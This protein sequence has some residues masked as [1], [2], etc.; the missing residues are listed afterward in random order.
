MYDNDDGLDNSTILYI[1]RVGDFIAAGTAYSADGGG[2]NFFD[3]NGW[4]R[5]EGFDS[6]SS[7]DPIRFSN[8]VW[9]I[10]GD[11]NTGGLWV[12][13]EN[14]V[15][16]YDWEGNWTRY[17][18][19][20]GLPSNFVTGL[21]F[22][23]NNVLIAA[24][25]NGAAWFDGSSF[26]P[27]EPTLGSVV[28]GFI[29]DNEGGYWF[30]GGGRIWR[31]NPEN[32]NWDTFEGANQF[33]TYTA[34]R[35]TQDDEGNLYFGSDG[36]G[37]IRYD[38]TS[39]TPFDTPNGPKQASSW[40]IIENPNGTLWFLEEWGSII[41][42]YDPSTASWT[43]RE[44]DFCCP[45][46]LAFDAEGRLWSGGGTGVWILGTSGTPT[47][48]T[49]EQGLPSDQVYQIAFAPDNVTWVS[50]DAGIVKLQKAEVMDVLN[51]DDM[52]IGSDF[53]NSVF[54][55]SDGAV[56]V[57]REGGVSRLTP[58]GNW[59]QFEI[60]TPFTESFSQVLAFA[61]DFNGSIWVGTYGDGIYRY[62]QG[63][64][65]QFTTNSLDVGLPSPDI[66]NITLAPDGSVWFSTTFGVARFDGQTWQTL[67]FEDGLSHWNVRDV[68][69]QFDGTVWF[70]T[71]GGITRWTP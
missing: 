63:T 56:W 64:W 69:V 43:A 4:W 46:P 6:T 24:T 8:K 70:A 37:L 23:W 71:S 32:A 39:F 20:N 53:T 36:A 14:G 13:T 60:G 31:Y 17:T 35:S 30:S 66:N 12:S 11:P 51:S 58:D 68:S 21:F 40:G 34:F 18:T 48:L 44:L 38:G 26:I 55:A 9:S 16:L 19:E 62:T 27:Y 45:V 15:G 54:Y 33:P 1:G 22:D 67:Y 52:G 10:V 29:Q 5:P 2:I 7:G 50:T 65:E 25:E 42:T 49:T 41:D 57:S 61:E 47:N 28:N 59:E 3:G